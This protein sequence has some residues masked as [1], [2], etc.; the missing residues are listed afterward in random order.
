MQ[1]YVTLSGEAISVADLSAEHRDYFERAHERY[2]G[3]DWRRFVDVVYRDNPVVI[4]GG[5]RMTREGLD[6]PLTRLLQDLDDR[7][8]IREEEIAPSAGDDLTEPLRDD[9]GMSVAEAADVKGVPR[10]TIH[11]AVE[12][13]ALVPVSRSPLRVS[14]FS[15]ERWE[16]DRAKQL[17][18]A[19]G[20]RA[21][22]A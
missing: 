8:G 18:G 4:T 15:L 13:G 6:H 22:S 5:G 9:E 21:R 12:R 3:G 14:R 2:R 20:A 7:L 19:A 1:I 17:A 11:R 10:M 16:P